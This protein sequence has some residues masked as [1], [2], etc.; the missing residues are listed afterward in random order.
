MLK[1]L[2]RKFIAITMLLVGLVLAAVLGSSLFSSALTQRGIVTEILERALSDGVAAA[3]IGD[4]SGEQSAELMLAVVVDVTPD[5]TIF[6]RTSFVANVSEQTLVDV[7]REALSSKADSGRSSGYAIAWMKT[8]TTWGWRVAL[9]DTYLRGATL[10][11]QALS[12]LMIFSISMGAIFVIAYVLS[13]WAL[14]PVQS[15]WEQ[16]RRFVSDASHELKTPLAV[17]LANTQILESDESIPKGA[18]RWVA[19]TSEEATHMKELVEDLLTLAR[20]DEQ[21]ATGQRDEASLATVDLTAL[22]SGC[23]LE[24]DAVA[25]ERGCSISCELAEGVAVA[26]EPGRLRRVVRTLLDNATKYAEEGTEVR[27]LLAR[28]GRRARL[29]VSNRGEVIAPEALAHLFDRFYRTDDARERQATGGF[30]LGLAIAKSL[31]EAMGGSI[32]ATSDERDGT[33]FTVTL[34]LSSRPPEP[35]RSLPRADDSAGAAGAEDA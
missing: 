25:F 29:S 12:S 32:G 34:P 9:V 2:R 20:A 23:A 16:Q 35:P 21:E 18:R 27:V 33:T 6:D 22:A 3:T 5:G 14:R 1:R 19:S 15:A 8:E 4:T 24:F 10:R 26:A 11:A 30:G 28:D 31:V 13:G 17:I 7:V